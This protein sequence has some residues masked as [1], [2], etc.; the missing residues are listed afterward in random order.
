M[1]NAKK[2]VVL[3]FKQSRTKNSVRKGCLNRDSGIVQLECR[4]FEKA[5][6]TK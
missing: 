1:K 6:E 4:H 2:I 5:K 3:A